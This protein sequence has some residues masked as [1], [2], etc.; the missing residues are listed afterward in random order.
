[1]VAHVLKH[2]LVGIPIDYLHPVNA[3][4]MLLDEIFEFEGI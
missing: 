4:V 1:V 3:S 2:V